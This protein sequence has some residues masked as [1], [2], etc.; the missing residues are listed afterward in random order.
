MFS[1]AK[2]TTL[3]TSGDQWN[4]SVCGPWD[5]P[6]INATELVFRVT[7]AEPATSIP[8]GNQTM[9]WN[10]SGEVNISI[11]DTSDDPI[12]SSD[13]T[14]R[15]YNPN[16]VDVTGYFSGAGHATADITQYT[17]YCHI[18][19]SGWGVN[20]SDWTFYGGNGT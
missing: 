8:A 4:Y 10:F 19:S 17:G 5:P 20:Q 2:N 16:D 11:K 7:T 9:Y 15:I 13:Y 6:E 14:V 12:S 18:N 3:A 1:S